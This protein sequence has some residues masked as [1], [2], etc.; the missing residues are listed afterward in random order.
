M[1]QSLTSL[2]DAH[3]REQDN[4]HNTHNT[5]NRYISSNINNIE[6][7]TEYNINYNTNY[8]INYNTDYNTDY[9]NNVEERSK[10]V[11]Q[12]Y[13]A[14]TPYKVLDAPGVLNDYYLNILDWKEDYVAIAL[15]E[16]VFLYNTETTEVSEVYAMGSGYISSIK[17][18]GDMLFIGESIGAIRAYDMVKEEFVGERQSHYTRV[19]ALSANQSIITSGEK[20]GMIVNNDLRCSKAISKFTGHTQEVCGLK[21]SPNKD[22]LAS[23]S[24]DNTVKIWKMSSPMATTLTGHS[25]AVKAFDWCKWK[26]NVLCTGGGAKDKSLRLW[27]VVGG[28]EIKRIATDSQVCTLTYLSRYKEMITSH[29]YQQN[30]L[31]LWKATGGIKL[32]KAFGTHDP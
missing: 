8:N 20:E 22:Y 9:V 30:D 5:H 21:W 23:G 11:E 6:Y 17:L 4:T 24:N 2:I 29:G 31:K 1:R 18:H 13:I 25:S 16:S 27:D 10:R 14:T 15:R 32:I 12:R 26:T 3:N 7:N 28:K 19:G